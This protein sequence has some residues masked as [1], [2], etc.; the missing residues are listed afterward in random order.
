MFAAAGCGD[1]YSNDYLNPIDGVGLENADLA[2]GIPDLPD[3]GS[4]DAD[5]VVAETVG[6]DTNADTPAA[7][8]VDAQAEV[9][10]GPSCV[11]TAELCNGADD[12][13]DGETDE[14]FPDLGASCDGDD[15]GGCAGGIWVCAAD[16][17]AAVCDEAAWPDCS[18]ADPCIASTPVEDPATCAVTC[19][20]T[21]IAPCC[22]NGVL[23]DGETCDGDCP[24]NCDDGASCTTDNQTGSAETCDIACTYEVGTDDGS[25]TDGDALTD[26]E[27][28]TDGLDWTHPAVFNGML[29]TIGE[30][31]EGLLTSAQCDLFFGDNYGLMWDRFD[32]STQFQDIWQGWGYEAGNTDNYASTADYNFEP[33][34]A[35]ADN[36]GVYSSFQILYR[37]QLLLEGDGTHCFSVDTGAGGFGPGDI[38]G[39]RNNCGRVYFDFDDSSLPLAETGYGSSESPTSGCV[40]AN[41]GVYDLALAARHYETYFY[42]PKFQVRYCFGGGSECTPDQ[43][44]TRQQLR[45]WGACLPNCNGKS[46]GDD[47]CGGSCG[48]C[49]G[50]ATCD[51]GQCI[52][53]CTADCAGKECGDD[54]CGGTCGSCGAG[55][56]CS[57][58][59]CMGNCTADCT[60]KQC[61]DDGCGGSCGSC[62]A[63]EN[64]DAGQCVTGPAVCGDGNLASGEFCD[65]GNTTTETP[66]DAASLPTDACISDCSVNMEK[67]GDGTP[68]SATGEQCDDG[69]TD[70]YDSCTSS[71]TTSDDHIG[72]ACYADGV[73][74]DE[75]DYTAGTIVGCDNVPATFGGCVR[76]CLRSIDP[77]FS[78]PLVYNPGG[79]CTLLAIKCEGGFACGFAPQPGDFDTCTA[80][81]DGYKLEE[82]VTNAAGSTITSRSCLKTCQAQADC[83]WRQWDARF[84]EWGQYQCLPSKSD[85][86]V[87]ICQ[88]IRTY[89]P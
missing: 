19:E 65:D 89:G 79:Y 33:N 17:S 2:T 75:V 76:A 77:G 25:D 73:D 28:V 18:N 49:G 48:T 50:E 72:D 43:E 38:A 44:L 13:C 70:D 66:P 29:A 68:D 15:P 63:G 22:G 78:Q 36:T 8:D 40:Q 62:D 82:T 74:Q 12:D 69:N 45:T 41:A 4:P 16:G 34:W 39:R 10:T 21:P 59:T 35:N 52:A 51:A 71:C 57:A 83:R 61:G 81:P 32:E 54:G 37:A 84:S 9:E 30:P 5:A 3:A 88:D 53:N 11:P 42:S 7:A 85:P 64:C 60:G 67:C 6:P 14:D 56:S 87:S 80:C 55:E 46:C 58:G 23:E 24:A 1:T 31:P 47:G 27:E 26:C 86:S 20:D